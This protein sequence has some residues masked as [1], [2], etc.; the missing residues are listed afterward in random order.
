MLR[1][2]LP[3]LHEEVNRLDALFQGLKGPGH[4][5]PHLP[6][7]K[8]EGI[9]DGRSVEHRHRIAIFHYAGHADEGR[10]LLEA[11]SA[12]AEGRP[13]PRAWPGCSAASAGCNWSSSTAARPSPRSTTC[14]GRGSGRR[15]HGATPSTTTS[16]RQFADG[17]LQELTAG[18]SVRDAFDQAQAIAEASPAATSR[19]RDTGSPEAPPRPRGAARTSPV[20]A[21]LPLGPPAPATGRHVEH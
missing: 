16:A 14:C 15:R 10:L 4:R 12:S 9:K 7:A 6:Y 5:L 19:R 1:G 8:L 2:E 13:T 21:R 20:D 17:L 3:E 11:R 18:R